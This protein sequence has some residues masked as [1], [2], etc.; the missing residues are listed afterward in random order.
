MLRA[1]VLLLLLACVGDG[2]ARDTRAATPSTEMEVEAAM[3][4]PEGLR[5]ALEARKWNRALPVRE[6]VQ[7]LV[8]FMI[9]DD[10]L[11]LRYLEQPTYGIAE[12]YAQRKVNCLS[13]TLVF[14]ALARASGMRAQVQAS[15]EALA[16]HI[17]DDTIYR[18][19]HVNAGIVA[20]GQPYTVDVGWRA[21]LAMR[22]PRTISDT[23]AIAL[24]HNNNAVERLLLGDKVGAA[25]AI[26]ASLALDPGNATTWSNAGVVD[27]RAGRHAAAERDYLQALKLR[28]DHLGALGNLVGLYRNTGATSRADSYEKRL[29]RAQAVDPF[30]Q[31]L[32]AQGLAASGAYGDA[33]AHFR[34]AIRLMPEEAQFHL[35]LAAAY[36]KQGNAI[37]AQ[38]AR[39][40]AARLEA[41]QASQR[42]IRDA[43]D[44]G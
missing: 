8:D 2:H 20:D 33:I 13:F 34:R 29:R 38:R 44:S 40:R 21:V 32:I 11:A 24:L 3:A 18:A 17:L 23:Q 39:D 15:D 9:A 36:E 31:F 27:W 30:S 1:M 7:A 6:R 41:A 19:T 35:G 14:V 26:Q 43:T 42:G 37:A 16:M 4:L 22:K 10:G 25:T 12:S 5:Q 28:R